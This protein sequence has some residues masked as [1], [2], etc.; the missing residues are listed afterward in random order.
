MEAET[1]AQIPGQTHA[2][3]EAEDMRV[4]RFLFE[5]GLICYPR[6]ASLLCFSSQS[7]GYPETSPVVQAEMICKTCRHMCT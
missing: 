7:D 2:V 1:A 3:E 5:T 4:K 6:L